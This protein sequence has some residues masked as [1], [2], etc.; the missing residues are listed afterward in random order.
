[1]QKICHYIDFNIA[2]MQFICKKYA[3]YATKIC[4]KYAKNMQNMH[5]SMY[6]HILHIY[7]LPTLLMYLTDPGPGPARDSDS[8]AS[9]CRRHGPQ[10]FAY[11]WNVLQ[12]TPCGVYLW[13]ESR[14]DTKNVSYRM[15]SA[16]A[17]DRHSS[18][19]DGGCSGTC[20]TT[21]ARLPRRVDGK[22]LCE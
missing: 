4:K 9:G 6:L 17:P 10:T 21:L 1:M 16:I 20:V 15:Y 12:F 3:Q 2:N 5:K 19:A 11:Q 18:E 7:A 22:S 8:G 13:L 14:A